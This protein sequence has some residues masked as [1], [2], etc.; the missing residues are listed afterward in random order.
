MRHVARSEAGIFAPPERRRRRWLR[1]L[2][3]AL[4]ALVVVLVLLAV[5]LLATALEMARGTPAL[6]PLLERTQAQTTVI[7]DSSGKPIAEL[8]G[9]VIARLCRV[10]PC[11]P[12]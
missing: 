6:S 10:R 7:Y 4:L 1:W 8:H 12:P 9:A 5:G 11:P 2:G 3:A